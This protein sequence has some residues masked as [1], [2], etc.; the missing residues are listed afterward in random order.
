MGTEKSLWTV[1][2]LSPCI[3]LL[4]SD[5]LREVKRQGELSSYLYKLSG[6]GLPYK[7]RM[8]AVTTNHLEWGYR[9][10]AQWLRVFD[11]FAKD[12]DLVPNTHIGQLTTACNSCS[13]L[14]PAGT[15][16]HEVHID[17]FRYTHAHT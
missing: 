11:A 6:L 15:C 17:T 10:S 13:P 4:C 8:G 16:M 7:N 3:V 5:G 14:G 12:P 9:Q 1:K 2:T